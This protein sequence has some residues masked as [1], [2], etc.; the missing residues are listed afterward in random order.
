[1]IFS[2]IFLMIDKISYYMIKFLTT[3]LEFLRGVYKLAGWGGRFL[4]VYRNKTGRLGA[5]FIS[6]CLQTRWLGRN[7]G[8]YEPKPPCSTN[9]QV[10]FLYTVQRTLPML[11]VEGFSNPEEKSSA[12][13]GKACLVRELS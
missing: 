3:K 10:D 1:M 6:A 7:S 11:F 9:I 12:G 8:F 2:M 4:M 5:G 13:G